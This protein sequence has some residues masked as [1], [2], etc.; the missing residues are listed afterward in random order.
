MV[1]LGKAPA[2]KETEPGAALGYKIYNNGQ[3]ENSKKK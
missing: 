1:L 2:V 3:A